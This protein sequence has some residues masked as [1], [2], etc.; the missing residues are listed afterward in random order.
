MSHDLN[1]AGHD[2][3]GVHPIQPVMQTGDR[4]RNE[5]FRI[6]G[7]LSDLTSYPTF[8]FRPPTVAQELE[9]ERPELG[10]PGDEGPATCEF[11]TADDS[12]FLWT[13]THWRLRL[14]SPS[15]L[16][17]T[18][19]LHSRDHWESLSEMPA[20]LASEF[21][22]LCARIESAILSLGTVAR[23]H[24]YRSGDG[25]AHFH[26]WFFARPLGRQQ[27]RGTFLSTWAQVLQPWPDDEVRAAGEAVA[28]ALAGDQGTR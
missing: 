7:D 12:R 26:T 4:S 6:K 24:L 3:A 11:C 8:P 18:V 17:G 14:H 19:M 15:S 25:H 13:D 20:E 2:V 9:P 23:V 28:R 22:I 10:R 27:F 1:G 16:P 5:R 21:G